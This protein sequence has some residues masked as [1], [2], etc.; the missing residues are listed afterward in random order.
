MDATVTRAL[1]I[2]DAIITSHE[3]RVN[4]EAGVLEVL[5]IAIN[6]YNG[7]TGRAVSLRPV[8]QED[9]N[10]SFFM[11]LDVVLSALN[12]NIGQISDDYNQN[13]QTIAVLASI[14][15]PYTTKAAT[16]VAQITGEAATW[17]PDR[18][19]NGMFAL[20]ENVIQEG[21]YFQNQNAQI[22]I[23]YVD[24]RK[25][26]VSLAANSA[27]NIHAALV[28]PGTE[29][30]MAYF[31][32]RRY[33]I[34]SDVNGAA[35]ASPPGLAL[36]V[37]QVP[38]RPGFIVA[39]NGQAPIGVA[40][41]ANQIGMIQIESLWHTS[42]DKTLNQ[43]PTLGAQIFNAYAYRTPTWHALRTSIFNQ[44]TLPNLLPPIHPPSDR[45]ELMTIIL[46]SK[47]ADVYTAL[48]P[49]FHVMGVQPAV[50]PVTRANVRAAYR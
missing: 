29:I 39:W 28:P 22:T 49:Q 15:I 8:T 30:V 13:L 3:P 42:L 12:I 10:N 2:L 24:S 45:N 47:L 1:A 17:G 14:E 5:G 16:T 27:G 11:C 34:F 26:Q 4:S 33:G 20:T 32:W 48:R 38:M 31:I 19:P 40:N 6:R 23:A 50:G 9:R 36:T 46:V 7:M 44:T 18:Q 37:D 41:N 35:V 25:A 21:R 43:V